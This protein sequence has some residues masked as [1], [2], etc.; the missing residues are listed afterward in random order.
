MKPERISFRA[1][2]N[3][4][5]V[6]L[7]RDLLG[8]FLIKEE[9]NSLLAGRIVEVEAYDAR[10]EASHSFKGPTPR[11][12][13]MFLPGGHLYVYFIYGVHFCCNVVSGRKGHGAAV[14]LRALEPVAGIQELSQRRF[15]TKSPDRNQFI[16]LLN[17]PAKICRAFKIDSAQNGLDLIKGNIY[18]ASEKSNIP[19]VAPFLDSRGTAEQIVSSK[20]IGISKSA[21]LLW[22][23]YFKDNLFVSRNDTR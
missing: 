23:F 20:R 22:R 10:D 8:K 18:I 15:A 14:L 1:F 19:A 13:V 16:S 2:Y 4:D 21:D 7:A 11:N 3:R 12:S 6:L 9:K 5:V 17:G